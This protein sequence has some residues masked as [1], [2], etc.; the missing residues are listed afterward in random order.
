MDR[1]KQPDDLPVS[2]GELLSLVRRYPLQIA[3]CVALSL[4]LVL[5]HVGSQTPIWEAQATLL[6]RH[7]ETGYTPGEPRVHP[8]DLRTVASEVVRLS[9]RG[10]AE[11]TVR[12]PYD[13]RPPTPQNEDSTRHLGLQTTVDDE[14][15]MPLRAFARRLV[16]SS[17]TDGRLYA[18]AW[19][20]NPN[21]PREVRVTF[22]SESTVRVGVPGRFGLTSAER[23]YPWRGQALD[24]D[25]L[26]LLLEPRGDVVGRSFRVRFHS[27]YDAVRGLMGRVHASEVEPNSGV[28][29]VS[30]YDTDPYRAAESANALCRNYLTLS[31]EDDSARAAGVRERLEEELS[32]VRYE[33]DRAYAELVN[34]RRSQPLSVDPG[35]S[36]KFLILEVADLEVALS[37]LKVELALVSEAVS[38]VEAGRIDALSKIAEST[39]DKSTRIMIQHIAELSAQA[40]LQER[41]DAGAYR[42]LLQTRLLELEGQRDQMVVQTR[43]LTQALAALSEE[44]RVAL[45]RLGGAGAPSIDHVTNV[46]IDRVAQLDAKREQLL[47]GDHTVDHPHVVELQAAVAEY[48]E[49]I[50][51]QLEAQLMSQRN[52][53]DEYDELVAGTRAVLQAHPE[54]ERA[55][56]LA[57]I[58]RLVPVVHG[59]LESLEYALTERVA[60]AEEEIGN[61][62]QSLT[63]LPAS[64]RDQVDSLQRVD[65]YKESVAALLKAMENARLASAFVEPPAD[66]I[67]PAVPPA[68]RQS[69]RL[70]FSLVLGAA[71]GL[72][73]GLALALLRERAFGRVR[74]EGEL[75]AVIDAAA[76]ARVPDLARLKHPVTSLRGLRTHLRDAPGGALAASYRGLRAGLGFSLRQR[77]LRLGVTSAAPGEGKSATAAGLANAVAGAGSRVLLVQTC[78]TADG[79]ALGFLPSLA[80][81]SRWSDAVVPSADLGVDVLPAGSTAAV[82]ADLFAGPGAAAVLDELTRSYDLI[83]L[84]LP[85]LAEGAEVDSLAPR[86]DG[87]LLVARDGETPRRAVGRAADRIRLAGGTLLGGVLNASGRGGYT[88]ELR[89]EEPVDED[90]DEPEEAAEDLAA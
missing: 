16:G 2:P 36:A 82:V 81:L 67:D 29:R 55:E 35:E 61:L 74:S 53:R 64:E 39:A 78:A 84:D 79:A 65:E 51:Q 38:D 52:R 10:A 87:L 68:V 45:S 62:R 19:S 4:V 27:E 8:M 43:S 1:A 13:G 75:A 63:D 7:E 25:G 40:G 44:G 21:A 26:Y 71:C 33:L 46:L 89:P 41:S 15:R 86:L 3:F 54:Q 66:L 59:H 80:G 30:V 32:R 9:S 22:P 17:L 28:L 58:D 77:G 31:V 34:L 72:A 88:P 56:I 20:D 11:R 70:G 5:W 90:W 69:P 57:A 85:C 83:V 23:D 24:Y 18:Q 6:L 76:L 14:S 48:L 49:R 50:E 37:E 42:H 12:A 60:S 73:A 47:A